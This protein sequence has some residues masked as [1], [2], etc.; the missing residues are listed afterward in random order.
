MIE[1]DQSYKLSVP[2]EKI[3]Q[4][5]T[6]NI[7][8]ITEDKTRILLTEYKDALKS[9]V[10]WITPTSVFLS[11]LATVITADFTAKMGISAELWNALFLVCTFG[12][13]I[14]SLVAGFHAK[15][16]PSL[17]DLIKELK[18]NNS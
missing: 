4:N 5:T 8:V 1:N 3:H 15:K 11:L 9:N 2:A 17:D 6:Q 14:W 12:T 7:I 10:A 13:G 18:S 16:R